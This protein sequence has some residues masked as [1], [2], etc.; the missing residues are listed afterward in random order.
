[1]KNMWRTLVR[2]LMGPVLIAGAV[3][4]ASPLDTIG[5]IVV[6]QDGKAAISKSL[7]EATYQTVER[8][9]PINPDRTFPLSD[10]YRISARV[11]DDQAKP[12]HFNQ[13]KVQFNWGRR[14]IARAAGPAYQKTVEA[15]FYSMFP[16]SKLRENGVA[17]LTTNKLALLCDLLTG[18]LE[19]EVDFT[20]TQE[21]EIIHAPRIS[22]ASVLRLAQGVQKYNLLA[23]PNAVDDGRLEIERPS[24]RRIRSGFLLGFEAAKITELQAGDID[25]LTIEALML[26]I[27]DSRT[28]T[29][30]PLSQVDADAIS[31]KTVVVEKVNKPF[32][33]KIKLKASETL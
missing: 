21:D 25:E 4:H 31:E 19:V 30:V 2:V 22:P 5:A 9:A 23:D 33:L 11:F 13:S 27:F 32:E 17:R 14:S 10:D 6:E 29:P 26:G 15:H 24:L 1:M 18:E 28:Q 8:V 16:S 3:A 12:R 20:G 7:C